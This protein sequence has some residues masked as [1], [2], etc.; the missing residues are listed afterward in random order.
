MQALRGPVLGGA[1]CHQQVPACSNHTATVR[2]LRCRGARLAPRL[3]AVSESTNNGKVRSKQLR[4]YYF[5]PANPEDVR[6]VVAKQHDIK[7]GHHHNGNGHSNGYANGNGNG[8]GMHSSNGHAVAH[9]APAQLVVK[10]PGKDSLQLQR[11]STQLEEARAAVAKLQ[12]YEVLYKESRMRTKQMQAEVTALQ[13]LLADKDAEL[14][15]QYKRMES[16]AMERSGLRSQ[17]TTAVDEVKSLRNELEEAR[18]AMLE[19]RGVIPPNVI[20]RRGSPR[21]V[22]DEGTAMNGVGGGAKDEMGSPDVLA[23]LQGLAKQLA[24]GMEQEVGSL[25]GGS[26]KRD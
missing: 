2:P 15:R 16:E 26:G 13:Q 12:Q 17:F 8:H 9:A 4:F 23:S 1:H 21:A 14:A 6:E 3:S 5:D 19:L 18:Q 10:E 24:E 7:S 22:L 20:T 11:L 25:F